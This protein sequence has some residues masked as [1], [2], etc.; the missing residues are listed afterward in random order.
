MRDDQDG[1]A[2]KIGSSAAT[3]LTI[4]RMRWTKVLLSQMS[5]AK[6][7]DL[8]PRASCP[9]SSAEPLSKRSSPDS[10]G[11]A[12][13]KTSFRASTSPPKRATRSQLLTHKQSVGITTLSHLTNKSRI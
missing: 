5:T 9:I 10:G 6:N 4:L 13:E 2:E 12:P 3:I 1:I 11:K 7:A 8:F